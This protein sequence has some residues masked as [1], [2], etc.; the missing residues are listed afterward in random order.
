MSSVKGWNEWDEREYQIILNNA[1]RFLL[2]FKS[3][4]RSVWVQYVCTELCLPLRISHFIFSSPFPAFDPLNS[5]CTQDRN[6][7]MNP[8]LIFSPTASFWS[9]SSQSPN[10][11]YTQLP[12]PQ[13]QRARVKVPIVRGKKDFLSRESLQLLFLAICIM[14]L[15][16]IPLYA[17][18]NPFYCSFFIIPRKGIIVHHYTNLVIIFPGKSPDLENFFRYYFIVIKFKKITLHRLL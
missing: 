8:E 9:H 4:Q 13:A 16:K 2:I 10:Y 1:Q 12:F 14:L 7:Y 3:Q 6:E 5:D 18:E 11:R 15:C 17:T